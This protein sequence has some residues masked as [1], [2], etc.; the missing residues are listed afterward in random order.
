VSKHLLSS[1]VSSWRV[2]E[3]G[4]SNLVGCLDKQRLV[5]LGCGVAALKWPRNGQGQ[6][7][8]HEHSVY[9]ASERTLKR[10]YFIHITRLQA[11]RRRSEISLKLDIDSDS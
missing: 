5:R 11:G 2:S 9:N 8:Y 6:G 1:I 3:Y 7:S 10:L 4:D